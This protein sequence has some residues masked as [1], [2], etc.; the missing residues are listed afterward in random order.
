MR[1]KVFREIE[2]GLK[3]AKDRTMELRKYVDS[4]ADN[5]IVVFKHDNIHDIWKYIENNYIRFWE[6]WDSD[7]LVGYSEAR[8]DKIIRGLK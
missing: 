4:K 7:G 1:K 8:R 5:Y 6:I 3:Q 2:K